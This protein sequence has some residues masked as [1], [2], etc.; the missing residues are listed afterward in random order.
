MKRADI[1]SILMFIL[2][3]AFF[4]GHAHAG[5]LPEIGDN[6][7]AFTHAI[8]LAVPAGPS[9]ATPE[10]QLLYSSAAGNGN[11]GVGWSLP[12]SAIR[13]DQS[14]GVPSYWLDGADPCDPESFEG[15]LWLDGAEL[16]PSRRDPLAPDRCTWR[17]RPDTFSLVVPIL[18]DRGCIDHDGPDVHLPSGYA[19]VRNDGTT[20]WYGATSCESPYVDRAGDGTPTRWLLQHVQDRDG[21]LVTYWPERGVGPAGPIDSWWSSAWSS[22][23][24]GC[25]GCLRAVTWAARAKDA[26][27]F[28]FGATIHGSPADS[29]TV[30]G[31]PYAAQQAGLT[32]KF[33]AFLADP[34]HFWP[35]IPSHYYAARIDWEPRPD[36]RTSFMSGGPE[37]LDRRIRQIAVFADVDVEHAPN[38]S[39][40]F[41]APQTTIRTFRLDYDQGSTGRSRLV[42]VWPIAGVYAADGDYSGELGSG[43]PQTGFDLWDQS[44]FASNPLVP[45]P[46]EFVWSESSVLDPDAPNGPEVPDWDVEMD[47]ANTDI[48]WMGA[49]WREGGFPTISMMDL[50][51]DALPDL[52]QHAEHLPRYLTAAGN[53]M[54][55]FN[56]YADIV[57]GANEEGVANDGVAS[58]HFWVRWNQGDGFSE[59]EPGPVDPFALQEVADWIARPDPDDPELTWEDLLPSVDELVE[60]GALSPEIAGDLDAFYAAAGADA[61][62][63]AWWTGGHSMGGLPFPPTLAAWCEH[64]SCA[65]FCEAGTTVTASLHALVRDTYPDVNA[66]ADDIVV[67]QTTKDA[68]GSDDLVLWRK[69]AVTRATSGDAVATL[70]D[71]PFNHDPILGGL[72]SDLEPRTITRWVDGYARASF[73]TRIAS[74]HIELLRREEQGPADPEEA[75]WLLVREGLVHDT[76]DINGDGYPDR[77]LGGAGILEHRL[78]DTTSTYSAPSEAIF[79]PDPNA[80]KDLVVS[81][82]HMPWFV[83]LYDPERAEFGE[84]RIWELP[85]THPWLLGGPDVFPAP[86]LE[87]N[88]PDPRL[89]GFH[90]DFNMLGV[91]ESTAKASAAPVSSRASASAGP[92]GVSAG[93][94]ASIGPVSIGGSI[95]GSGTS[96]SVGIGPVSF[97]SGGMSV[98]PVSIDYGTG[99]Q[100][101]AGAAVAAIW[102]VIQRALEVL[103]VPYDVGITATSDGLAVQAGPV[104]GDCVTCRPNV[105]FKRQGLVDLNG[106]GLLD[107]VRSNR[108]QDGDEGPDW[109]VVLNE[110]DGFSTEPMAWPGVRT[111]YMDASLT[112]IYRNGLYG[113]AR[114]AYRRA[115]DVAGLRD[116][117][118]DGLPDFVYTG[119]QGGASCE[120]P[121]QSASDTHTGP[122]WRWLRRPEWIQDRQDRITL[123]VQLN[124]GRGFEQPLDWFPGGVPAEVFSNPQIVPALSASH[125]YTERSP[126]YNDGFGLGIIG[127]HDVNGDGLVDF[128]VMKP[129]DSGGEESRAPTVYLNDGQRFVTTDIDH[130]SRYGRFV[131]RTGSLYERQSHPMGPVSAM[132]DAA[133]P[134]IDVSRIH[135]RPGGPVVQSA[136]LDLNGDG[137]LDWAQSTPYDVDLTQPE[138]KI[139]L[140]PLQD[141]VPDVLVQLWQPGGG[142]QRMTYAPARDF[143]DLPHAPDGA[144]L[145]DGSSLTDDVEDVYPASAQ[146]LTSRVIY[147][148]L[149]VRGSDPVGVVYQ[150]GDPDF[151]MADPALMAG[152]GVTHP[153]FRRRP[154]GFARVV[155][156]PCE[157]EDIDA[158]GVC[159]DRAFERPVTVVQE[160][161]TDWMTASLPW[162]QRVIDSQGRVRSRQTTHWDGWSFVGNYELDVRPESS[163]TR[164]NWHLAP[165][166]VES[167]AYDE[168]GAVVRSAVQTGYSP[169]N[170]M[171]IC[172]GS[173]LDGDGWVDRTDW[174]LWEDAYI[175]DGK[176]DAARMTG[177]SMLPLGAQNVLDPPVCGERSEVQSNTHAVRRTT[178]SRYP[179]GRVEEATTYDVATGD[180][181]S[182]LHDYLP[183]GMPYLQQDAAGA[184]WFT[185]YEPTTGAVP[186]G[187]IGPPNLAAGVEFAT[188]RQVCGLTSACAPAAWG[189]VSTETDASGLRSFTDYDALG[190]PIASW[191]DLHADVSKLVYAR[192]LRSV[193]VNEEPVGFAGGLPAYVAAMRPV[194]P[195]IDLWTHTWTDGLG[196]T[197]LVAEDWED[198]QG[199][200]GQRIAGGEQR[201]WRGR[202]VKA[203]WPCFVPGGGM[204]SQAAWLQYQPAMGDLGLC[205]DAPPRDE[206]DYDDL[207]RVV[208][209]T[210]P[211][212]ATLSTRL[213]H[214]GGAS[215]AEVELFEGGSVLSRTRTVSTPLSKATTRYDAVTHTHDTG[216]LLPAGVVAGPFEL[217]TMEW[218]DALGRRTQVWRTGQGPERTTF[219][220]DGFDRLFAYADPD[221]GSW[222][223][224]YDPAGRM[225][226]RR[227]VDPVSNATELATEWEFDAQG[228]V[229]TE[230]SYDDAGAWQSG[231]ASSWWEWAYDVDPGSMAPGGPMTAAGGELGKASRA[232]RYRAGACGGPGVDAEE[233]LSWRYDRRGRPVEEAFAM[234]SCAWQGT[235][236]PGA[237]VAQH[238][239]TAGDA[240]ARTWMPWL[241]E[242]ITW[243]YDGAG[244]PQSVADSSG[245]LVEARYEIQGRLSSLD[246]ANGVQQEYLYAS[247]QASTQALTNSLTWNA[248]GAA[249]FAREYD[250]NAAGELRSWKDDATVG[251]TPEQWDCEYDGIGALLGCQ[252]RTQPEWF[253]YS[254]DVLGNLIAEDVEVDGA[255]LWA[256]QYARG[257]G[258]MASVPGVTVPLN[259]PVARVL[260]PTSSSSPSEPGQSFFY[261]GRGH[262]TAQRYHDPAASAGAQVT[263]AGLADPGL[264]LL[265]PIWQRRFLWNAG[266]RLDSVR[267]QAPGIDQQVSQSWYGPG[268]SRLAERVTPLAS[269]PDPTWTQSRSWAGI[270]TAEPELEKPRFTLSITLGS[271]VVAQKTVE[272]N[273][274]GQPTETM[275]FLGGDHLG[276]A[277]IITDA[278]GDLVRG[279]RYEPY[280]RIRD[281]WGPE[282]ASDDYALAGVDDLFNGKPRNRKAFGLTD[283][284]GGEY[285]LE[286]YD[287]G[288]RIYLPELSRWAS[289]DSITPDTVWEANA[290]TYVRNNPLKYRDPDG[291][292]AG[293][294][295]VA[296]RS[297]PDLRPDLLGRLDQAARGLAAAVDS[298]NADIQVEIERLGFELGPGAHG[299]FAGPAG[300]VPSHLIAYV[301]GDAVEG[302]TSFV[303]ALLSHR[304]G[305]GN[306]ENGVIV[307]VGVTSLVL[308]L[309][310]RGSFLGRLR[311]RS[312]PGDTI[313]QGLAPKRATNV[314]DAASAARRWLGDDARVIA[315]DAG[316]KIFV[317]EAGTRRLRFDIDRPNPHKSPHGHVEELVDGNWQKSGPIYP[318]DVVPE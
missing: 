142:T 95:S 5:A 284:M 140:Y 18:A 202:V 80:L 200:S 269:E 141:A 262:L 21:N 264:G 251:G 215:V 310:G 114:P 129:S 110:G 6:S 305:D 105:R 111:G 258:S 260:G 306:V 195:G 309:A 143:M 84:T 39:V 2:C 170:G 49:N 189:Q 184:R 291:H 235:G 250:W 159:T 172:T 150:Y 77:V 103:E 246:Y 92:T 79:N 66:S 14:W 248:S 315:N 218:Q 295:A 194:A 311:S 41:T 78:K 274:L 249:L 167:E 230:W 307:A 147:D 125:L 190:R 112:D 182:E 293:L 97:T 163:F 133:Y 31:P 280:G 68:Q 138:A 220:F 153:S 244:R 271:T 55:L 154:L 28:A 61:L 193:A 54:D 63:G 216:S 37:R 107:Y 157:A 181:L 145:P 240:K 276:S 144:A 82:Q 266:G 223:L 222:E 313:T 40:L 52:V 185:V 208:L 204:T 263:T 199:Q 51:G 160:Y 225:R 32:G 85:L 20:W 109:V 24:E 239:W 299:P 211:D 232:V 4:A 296:I 90:G 178:F 44:S 188:T 34:G 288:A 176:R 236:A 30:A 217:R 294:D 135:R 1:T 180:L 168:A 279:V 205:A 17:T 146:L 201:D 285:A 237:L 318:T 119:L 83:A 75:P 206:F 47:V 15:R 122:M 12:Y 104:G 197:L 13:L 16:I 91:W 136:W 74:D 22:G 11:A 196:R 214:L 245:K 106:D 132:L 25:D 213:S 317:N 229:L 177:V 50:N 102:F 35:S 108:V 212:G 8:P 316:D 137:R 123:C 139:R 62:C 53:L 286:G 127:L 161:G 149:G 99:V 192:P 130:A 290:F 9:G 58:E 33:T 277:S 312:R 238:E 301:L 70:A 209:R 59:L 101:G 100:S 302:G 207:S 174:T 88:E 191:D 86:D 89:F 27:E 152:D 261:D 7:G 175:D 243:R 19:V 300:E 298:W 162:E 292:A 38:G 124:N 158:S 10:L 265:T 268:G 148:G 186:I 273:A 267:V 56:P 126:L 253:E 234:H 120:P 169:R 233:A 275:R 45:N 36:V 93:L 308:P 187:E 48:P 272:P 67:R 121:P 221:Q 131:L 231:Q 255:S 73:Q 297:G 43:F 219:A 173:D 283:T 29:V 257:T 259:A 60:D 72:G 42:R 64:R 87:W 155:A 46:W 252:N 227:L 254:Y 94:S 57:F 76:I 226:A 224:D 179:S 151:V 116:M 128:T 256:A 164:F 203:P 96:L 23:T 98:G 65:P 287:Y 26:T 282:A 166:L 281:E 165:T 134:V 115:H 278:N 117:N 289:A 183:N 3:S 69:Y 303:S 304:P 247:G 156:Q 210:R 198:E 314:D 118:G 270:R 242:E 228:R 81:T 71:I 171:A 241:G 113:N